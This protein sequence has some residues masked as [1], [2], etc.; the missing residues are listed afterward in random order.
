MLHEVSLLVTAR[1]NPS[2]NIGFLEKKGKKEIWSHLRNGSSFVLAP[3][4]VPKESTPNS[5]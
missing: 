3:V 1:C 2:C 5:K 4:S